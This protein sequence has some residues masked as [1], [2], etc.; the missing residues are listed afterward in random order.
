[1]CYI[2]LLMNV[3]GIKTVSLLPYDGIICEAQRTTSRKLGS[4]WKKFNVGD[5]E[6]SDEL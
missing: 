3:D 6:R 5:D 4:V 1:M 2:N